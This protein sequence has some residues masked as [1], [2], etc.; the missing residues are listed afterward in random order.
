MILATASLVRHQIMI[1][2]M[3]GGPF[4]HNNVPR[5]GDHGDPVWV[6]ELPVPLAN[7]PELELEVAFF[8]EYLDPVIVGVSHN[9]LVI[10][11]DGNTT[12]LS[13]LTFQDTKLTELAVV[14]HFLAS[15]LR[16]WRIDDRG[17]GHWS[18][19]RGGGAHGQ[20]D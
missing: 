3:S 9:D 17:R 15:D 19:Q 18:C 7:F 6:E 13:E 10:L 1:Y 8:V 5:G 11:G 12:R 4:S 2:L 14:D 16:L 20:R